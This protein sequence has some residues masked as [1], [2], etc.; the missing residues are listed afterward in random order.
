MTIFESKRDEIENIYYITRSSAICQYGSE[1]FCLS[2]FLHAFPV[3]TKILKLIM[4]FKMGICDKKGVFLLFIYLIVQS[5]SG[6]TTPVECVQ[7]GHTEELVCAGSQIGA[8]KIWDLEAAKMV[9]TLNGHRA[10][11]RCI[12]FH[13][14]GDF[15]TSGSLDTSIKVCNS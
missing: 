1:V 9:R 8:L 5:L 4:H 7:F 11:V 10:S 12:D 13:P 3:G 6:H 15:L 2:L 14:Y